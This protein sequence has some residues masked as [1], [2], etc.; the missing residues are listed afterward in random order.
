MPEILFG[1]NPIRE[2]LR[3][4]R[5]A[6][7][8][9]YYFQEK[10]DPLLTEVLLEFEK[11][12]V[13]VQT[14]QRKWLEEKAKGALTQGWLAEVGDYPYVAMENILERVA[15]KQDATVLALD[16]VQDPQN[17][18]AVLRSAECAGVDG[19]LIPEHRSSLVSPTVSKVAAG[20]EEYLWIS[21]VTNLVRALEAFKK[22]GFWVVGSAPAEPGVASQ[23]VQAF[24]WPEKTLLVL[25]AEGEGM[26]RLTR[27]TC[28]FLI[29]LPLAGRIGS[30][31]VSAAGAVFLFER[32]RKKRI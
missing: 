24:D 1:K 8:R 11:L 25:G 29:H 12:G 10:P 32:I 7:K 22:V 14:V 30:L 5:R 19:V 9:F 6:F 20:A 3:A 15:G 21:H 27:E 16:Q 4:G 2:A 23:E 26:R 17:L 31:N 18:G 13:P 28:D